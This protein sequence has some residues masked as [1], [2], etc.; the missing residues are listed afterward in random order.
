MSSRI[1][2]YDIEK[3]NTGGEDTTYGQIFGFLVFTRRPDGSHTN[4][5]ALHDDAHWAGIQTR[6]A[7]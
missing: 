5:L 7:V 6:D 2:G 4:I 1:L 3:I